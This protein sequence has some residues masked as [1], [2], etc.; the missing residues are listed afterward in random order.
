MNYAED[1]APEERARLIPGVPILVVHAGS[2]AH[3]THVEP[4]AGGIDDVDIIGVYIDTLSRYLGL[5]SGVERGSHVQIGKWDCSSYELRHFVRLAMACNPNVICALWTEEH[6][7]LWK[8]VL[9]SVLI[10]NRALF[11]SKLA[12]NTFSG[13]AGSQLARM[14]SYHLGGE[15]ECCDGKEFHTETCALT[16]ERGRGSRKKFATGYMGAKRKA[17]VEKFGFD[18]KNAAHLIRL[19]RMGQ[20]FLTTGMLNVRRHDAKELIEIKQGKWSMDRIMTTAMDLSDK[21]AHARD[22]SPLP[23]EPD[24][25]RIETM[26]ME[27]LSNHFNGEIALRSNRFAERMT[28]FQDYMQPAVVENPS[29]VT[30]KDNMGCSETGPG[31]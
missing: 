3:G 23:D 29:F 8:S 6:H 1:L 14:M 15:V 9:A 12:Y 4:E 5:R 16:K 25:A 2:V 11:S 21:M 27:I 20:E 10:R 24:S 7:H 22:V 13:Y 17:L 31:V 19:L 18:C 30:K 26:L 28:F